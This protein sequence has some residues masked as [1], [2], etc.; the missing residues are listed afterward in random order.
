MTKRTSPGARALSLLLTLSLLC[1]LLGTSALARE[2]DFF[3]AWPDTVDF[4][5]LTYGPADSTEFD[6]LVAELEQA[7]AGE[8]NYLRVVSLLNQ[9]DEVWSRMYTEYTVCMVAYYRD[10]ST[11]TE[12]YVAWSQMMTQVQNDYI[13]VERTLLE[14]QYGPAIA[15]AWGSDVETLLAELSPDSPEQLELLAQEQDLV[16]QY[17]DAVT[18]EYTVEYQG[19]SW[20]QAALDTDRSLSDQEARAV[21]DLLDQAVNAAT[22]PILVEMVDVRNQYARSKGYDNYAE[23]AYEAVYSR[24]YSLSDARQLYEQVKEYIVPVFNAQTLPLAYNTT[25]DSG[26]LEPYTSD[27]TQDEM[28]DLV[29]PYM[30]QVSSEYADLF[31]YM[32]QGNLADIGPSAT[33]LAVGFTTGLPAYSSA[34]MFNSPDGSYYDVETLIHEFGHYAEYC[35][36]SAGGDG[37]DCIDVAE[38]DSQMLE[39]LFLQ[40]ADEMFQEGGD[41]YR[42]RVI[43]QVV[44]SVVTGCY[45]DEFQTALYTDGDM[46]V[47]EIN[48]LAGELAQEYGGMSLFGGDPS[49]TWV[50]VS[51][52]FESPMYY[53]SY[54][55]SALSA[56]ELFLDAQE[57][58]D[59]AADTY[60]ALVARGTGMGYREAVRKAGLT[61]F[62]QAGTM[63][64]LAQALQAYLNREVYDLSSFADLQNH[65]AADAA[66]TCAGVGL[67]QGD[68]EG[69]FRPDQDMTRAQLVTVLWRL[70]GEPEEDWDT[71]LY[72]D[73]SGDAWYADGV[74]WATQE[75]IAG[76]VNDPLPGQQAYF[77][78]DGV[79][80]REQLAVMFYRLINGDVNGD[81]TGALDGFSDAA[82]VSSWAEAAMDWAVDKGLLTGKPGNLLDPQG[83]VTRA[84]AATLIQRLLVR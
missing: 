22:A 5:T 11:A 10:P 24:D 28:M 65:W 68:A 17:W 6:A 27:L 30:E 33:K 38:M 67:F 50:Q 76:G 21:Q 47:E 20:T 75:G 42:A 34:V 84:E 51:H 52:T 14:S 58:F 78:P 59:A 79:I 45:Y 31:D 39:L 60:L 18:K 80:T 13:G 16:T 63:A 37:G 72:G 9:M 8:G 1:G 23:Y 29:A 48:A 36:S 64:D 25:L 26:L 46:T 15:R 81:L 49:Y 56:L 3:D 7:A 71:G 53:I 40:F 83:S 55:T 43:Y 41:A 62:F 35:L 77:A 44:S 61:D 74:F 19:K 73:V 82:S 4:S 54:A 32:R 57:D 66:W 70:M 2:T 69:N 12:D